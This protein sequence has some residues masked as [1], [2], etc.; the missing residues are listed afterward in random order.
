MLSTILSASEIKKAVADGEIVIDPFDET[1]LKPASYTFTLGECVRT[2]E[3]VRSVVIDSRAEPKFR[4]FKIEEDGH[5]FGPSA[6]AVFQTKE[7]LQLGENIACFLSMRG[8]CVQIGIDA[9]R[10]EIFCEPGSKG[11]WDGRLMLE[12]SFGALVRLF[13]GIPIVKAVFFRVA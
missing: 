13:P 1:N 3:P 9:L 11:G 2:V 10:S 8:K 7:K 12:T 4:E 6:F 5:V